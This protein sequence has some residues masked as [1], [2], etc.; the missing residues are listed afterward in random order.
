M[1][2]ILVAFGG[3]LAKRESDRRSERIK[4]GLARRKSEGKPVGRQP[5][6]G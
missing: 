5:R 4:I 6:C 2:G 1:Q 3:W